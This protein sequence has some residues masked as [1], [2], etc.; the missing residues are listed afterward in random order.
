[1]PQNFYFTFRVRF[2]FTSK[3][4]ISSHKSNSDADAIQQSHNN[5]NANKTTMLTQETACALGRTYILLP[6]KS[7]PA[8]LRRSR[9]LGKKKNMIIDK[10]C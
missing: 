4:S 6:S 8:L 10:Y 5:H 9:I 3:N 7:I 1:M 2:S